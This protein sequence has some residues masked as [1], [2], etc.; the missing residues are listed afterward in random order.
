MAT[1][2]R[3]LEQRELDQL[4]LDLHPNEASGLLTVEDRAILDAHDWEYAFW[5]VMDEG[6]VED[7]VGVIGH[8]RGAGISEGWEIDRFHASLK[9]DPG[10]T[11]DSES[12]ARHEGWIFVFG[13]FFGG[14][15]GPL[16][17]KRGFVARFR[18]SEVEHAFTDPAVEIEV[19][20]EPF[21]LHRLINDA[22]AA[23]GLDLVELGPES[24]AALIR[25]T[26][27]RGREKGKKWAGL[28]REGDY[29][30]NFEGAA[31]RSSGSL[32]FGLRFPTTAEGLPILV[33]M[34]G[35]ERLFDGGGAP[36]VAGFFVVD[37]V[38]KD[39][40]MAGVRDL[41][42]RA[43]PEGE[44]LHV[45]TGNIDSKK[46]GSVLIKDYP[47]GRDTMAT[48][49]KCR[50]P[51]GRRSE[52]LSAEF[53]REFPELPRVEGIAITEDD[54]FFYVTDEDEGVHLRHT[55][56]LTS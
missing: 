24:K 1:E 37:A 43:T 21:V 23:S 32:L 30:L 11:E 4:D 44:E 16:Q 17:P 34:E 6:R 36:S 14:K 35:V 2:E 22:L 38:G 27:E 50:L 9:G 52:P 46:G 31:F 15:S 28:V 54:S 42:I 51:E 8:K 20:R 29:P 55:R 33:E 25:A 40:E 56:L 10:K 45:V 19:H 49:F 18:E 47:P 13:S 41:A 7:C 5:V 26:I 48:H 3:D 39:G 12:V 53:V